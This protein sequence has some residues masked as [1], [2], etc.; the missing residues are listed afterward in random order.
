VMTGC[1]GS[2]PLIGI[3]EHPS[4]KAKGLLYDSVKFRS[5]S[6]Y[7]GGELN[8]GVATNVTIRNIGQTGFIRV[9]VYLKCSEGEWSRS[10]EI[11]LCPGE[12][13][14]LN[15]FFHEPTHNAV[16][17]ECRATTSP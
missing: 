8:Y 9:T 1:E 17:I 14:T 3:S 10:E 15:Y 11:P 2:A 5:E 13:K 7:I 12:Y 16:N 4:N 6:R